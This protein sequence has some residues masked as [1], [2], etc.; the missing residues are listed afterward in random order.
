ME[1]SLATAVPAEQVLAYYFSGAFDALQ[2]HLDRIAPT[3]RLPH[4]KSWID[5]AIKQRGMTDAL[6]FIFRIAMHPEYAAFFESIALAWRQGIF[7]VHSSFFTTRVCISFFDHPKIPR[8]EIDYQYYLYDQNGTRIATGRRTLKAR[9]T[10]TFAMA[11]LFPVRDG[12]QCG[13]FF[14]ETAETYLGSLRMYAQWFNDHCMTTTHEKAALKNNLQLLV[15]PTIIC[16]ATHETFMAIANTSDAVLH[17]KLQLINSQGAYYGGVLQL[18]FQP[19]CSSLV[20]ISANFPKAR[21]FL[22]GAPGAL[23]IE[24]NLVNAMYYYFIYNT[25]LNIWQI[26]HL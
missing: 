20:G 6:P 23:Y 26:Q 4:A 21:E 12:L 17:L 11:D 3:D 18:S 24:N 7:A 19:H 10:H 8:R 5:A 13:T 14:L 1:Q 15:T 16:D 2:Q 9:H 25:A 22:A